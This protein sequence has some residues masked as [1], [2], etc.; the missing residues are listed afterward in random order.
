MQVGAGGSGDPDMEQQLRNVRDAY[1]AT[2]RAHAELL[3]CQSSARHLRA[4]VRGGHDD[5]DDNCNDDD[6]SVDWPAPPHSENS[7]AERLEASLRHLCSLFLKAPDKVCA[8][9]FS[10]MYY[11]CCCARV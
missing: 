3:C 4:V 9:D 5:N 11:Q 1:D 2:V 8:V 7:L 6:G 10:F